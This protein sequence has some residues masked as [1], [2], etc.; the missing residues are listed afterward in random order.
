MALPTS[1]LQEFLAQNK[2]YKIIDNR[3]NSTIIQLPSGELIKILSEY[4]LEVISSTGYGLEERLDEAENFTTFKNFS[5]PTR[6]LT[7]KGVVRAYTMPNFP[8]VDFTN[9]YVDIFNL[10]SYAQLH[11][12]IEGNI[13]QGNELG[14][15]FPDLCTT[16]NIRISKDGKVYFLDYELNQI[17]HMPA[18]GFST[19]LGTEEEIL[20]PKYFDSKTCLFDKEIDIRS[21]I[22]LYFIDTFGVNLTAVN[23]INP[24]TGNKVTIDLVFQTIDL[25][26]PDIQHKVWKIFQ[27]NEHNEFLG[28]DMYKIAEKYMLVPDMSVGGMIKKLIRK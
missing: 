20:I 28:D 2:G 8:G 14:I 6:K 5:V 1:D 27:D 15:V 7:D 23:K 9:Y 12:Q 17:K 11:S 22:I 3:E 24:H 19:L 21:A 16:E 25:Q 4:L 18:A 26:E 10:M 13:K